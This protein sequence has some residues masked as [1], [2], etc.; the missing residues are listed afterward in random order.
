MAASRCS[1]GSYGWSS[2]GRFHH[3]QSQVH[4]FLNTLGGYVKSVNTYSSAAAAVILP[5]VI[6][7]QES[8]G[9]E[10]VS[11]DELATQTEMV[12]A[13]GG[14]PLKNTSVSS[15]GT[16]QHIARDHLLAAHRRGTRFHLISPL[17]DDLPPDVQATWHPIRPGTDVAMMLGIAHTLMTEDLHDR[18]F[19]ERYCVGYAEFEGYLCGRADG[20]PKDAAW[21]AGICDMPAETIQAH[22]PAGRGPAHTDY[23]RAVAAARRTR[24]TAGLDGRRARRHAGADRPAGRRFRL[25]DGISWPM[26]GSRRWPSRCQPCRRAKTRS[27]T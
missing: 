6:G 22:R 21:A 7:S 13:F 5:H 19:L 25:R 23:L 4:R 27:P 17:R 2:A 26:W 11:W 12:L 18:A 3:A 10:N 24:R 16:S 20:Q 8:A 14:L 1:A 15:G 9:R